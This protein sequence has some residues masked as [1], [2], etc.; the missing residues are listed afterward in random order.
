MKKILLKPAFRF[1]SVANKSKQLDSQ[2]RAFLLLPILQPNDMDIHLGHGRF[3]VRF[4]SCW[5][6]TRDW[7]LGVPLSTSLSPDHPTQQPFCSLRKMSNGLKTKDSD[8]QLSDIL[9]SWQRSLS[10]ALTHSKGLNQVLLATHC[11]QQ[12]TTGEKSIFSRD[13]EWHL[14]HPLRSKPSLKTMLKNVQ[15]ISDFQNL[16][17]LFLL[18]SRE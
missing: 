12:S 10:P 13:K 17:L 6:Q 11:L 14:K 3:T 9:C 1:C 4:S 16:S 8:A 7:A 5:N 15:W 18:F 2:T